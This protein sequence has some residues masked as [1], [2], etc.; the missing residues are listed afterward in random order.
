MD[1]RRSTS[2][3]SRSFLAT[4]SVRSS[5][6]GKEAFSRFSTSVA[7]EE[8]ITPNVEVKHPKF[9]INGQFVDSVSGKTFP[10]LDPRTGEA[11]ANVSEASV[12]DLDLAVAAARK[13]FDEGP[14]PKMTAY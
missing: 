12:E 14:W 3:L 10:T 2:L 4:S 7:T 1:T 8:P 9:L 11:I 5:T 13:A 6:G